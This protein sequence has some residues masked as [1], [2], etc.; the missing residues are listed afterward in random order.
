MIGFAYTKD[1]Y[2]AEVERLTL[3]LTQSVS[4]EI[5][6]QLQNELT[7]AR[8]HLIDIEN[9]TQPVYDPA[10]NGNQGS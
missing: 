7:S 4:R 5:R 6:A 9:N 2:R 1:F 8:A 10:D 3:L